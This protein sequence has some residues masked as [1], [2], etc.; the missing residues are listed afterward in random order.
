MKLSLPALL[1]AGRRFAA[2]VILPTTRRRT[3]SP[4]QARH[5]RRG[6]FLAGLTLASFLALHPPAA[7]AQDPNW[8]SEQWIGTW[9]AGPGG[10]PLP[11]T[12]MTYTNQTLRLIVHTSVG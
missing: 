2:G 5:A 11:A 1:D 8:S 7:H 10:P 3:F 6:F 12:T 4:E 9:G